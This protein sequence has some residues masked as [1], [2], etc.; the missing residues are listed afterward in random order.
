MLLADAIDAFLLFK[1]AENL[2]EATVIWYQHHLTVFLQHMPTTTRTRTLTPRDIAAYMATQTKRQPPL[3]PYTLRGRYACLR[4][5]FNWCE[6]YEETQPFTSPIGHGH[7][8]RVKAPRTGTPAPKYISFDHYTRYI[9]SINTQ[10]W[11][12]ARDR[13]L[14]IVLF[15]TGVRLQE[16]TNLCVEDFDTHRGLLTIKQGKGRKARTVPF[17]VETI[18]PALLQYL[19]MRPTWDDSHLW[20]SQTND[21]RQLTTPLQPEGIRQI[22]IRRCRSARI[23]YYNP[24]AWRH[25][26]AMWLIN[27]GASM[28]AVSV[29]M[30]HSSVQVTEH[31]YAHMQTP[32]VQREYAAAVAYIKQNAGTRLPLW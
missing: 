7:L 15:W 1:Q 25:A 23:P 22:L 27:C 18:R 20:L 6:T 2:S 32:A 4:A 29:V 11:K 21:S 31:V 12:G 5:F 24:H 10:T 3:A 8:K 28:A 26:F 19:Y 13:L 14:G 30:G 9:N 16:C 17:D